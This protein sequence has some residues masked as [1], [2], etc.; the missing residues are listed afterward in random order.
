MKLPEA[1]MKIHIDADGKQYYI[2]SK[3]GTYTGVMFG[4]I[5]GKL[6]KTDKITV[7][8]NNYTM[9]TNIYW[10]LSDLVGKKDGSV[11]CFINYKSILREDLGKYPPVE[12]D[13]EFGRNDVYLN[14]V[15]S[16]Q[17]FDYVG[18]DKDKVTVAQVFEFDKNVVIANAALKNEELSKHKDI[19][20]GQSVTYKLEL[21]NTSEE[22]SMD[23][24]GAYD[25]LPQTYGRFEWSKDNVS[26]KAI[27]SLPEGNTTADVWRISDKNRAGEETGRY[28]IY[29]NDSETDETAAKIK[30]KPN[31]S[32]YIYVTLT[33]PLD[34]AVWSEYENDTFD[35]G[36]KLI[37]S[38]YVGDRQASVEHQIKASGEGMLQKGVYGVYRRNEG[39]SN[40]I[41]VVNSGDRN[42]YKNQA[43]DYDVVSYYVTIY[44]SGNARLYL[45]DI[46]DVLPK[47]FEYNAMFA[48]SDYGTG[49]DCYSGGD[50]YSSNFYKRANGKF[51]NYS[52]YLRTFPYA[53]GDKQDKNNLLA[54]VEDGDR[55]IQYM[56]AYIKE[57][58]I[59]TTNADG[60]VSQKLKFSVLQK[61]PDAT[62]SNTPDTYT[63]GN[64]KYDE[65]RG[66]CYLEKGQA[67]VFGYQ[68]KIL[69]ADQTDD[70]ANNRIAMQYYDYNDAGGFRLS[71]NVDVDA[72]YADYLDSVNDGSSYLTNDLEAS[73]GGF[74]GPYGG[75][76][77]TS[78][79]ALNRGRIIPG[80][81]KTLSAVM[82]DKGETKPV[83]N[84]ALIASSDIAVWTVT[85]TNDGTNS[86]DG[87]TISDEMQAPYYF[88]GDISYYLENGRKT[89]FS[90][91]YN[92]RN[93][94][95]SYNNNR[96]TWKDTNPDAL[97]MDVKF[98]DAAGNEIEKSIKELGK[99]NVWV[100]FKTGE[101]TAQNVYELTEHTVALGEECTFTSV[102]AGSHDTSWNVA[103]QEFTVL[104]DVNEKGNC[105]LDITVR[106]H[107]PSL[108]IPVSGKAVLTVRTKKPAS[109]LAY[110]SY[111]NTA[112]LAPDQY[113]E[114]DAVSKGAVIRDENDNPVSVESTS[115]L[116]LSGA[117]AT[118]SWKDITDN[119]DPTNTASSL[120]TSDNY[121][122]LKWDETKEPPYSDFTYSLNVQ[123]KCDNP[124]YKMV[125]I[126]N[127]PD[128]GDFAAYS[129]GTIARNS[130]FE[131]SLTGTDVF[132]VSDG[133]NM[134]Q[135]VDE[136]SE[137]GELVY[138]AEFS[139]GV[140]FT[141][142]DWSGKDTAQWMSF[143]EVNEKLA[144]GE[145]NMS[146]IRSYRIIVSGD[147]DH[148]ITMGGTLK[149]TANARISGENVKPNEIAW[150]N[151]GYKYYVSLGEN[152]NFALS[153]SSLNVGVKTATIPKLKKELRS[154]TGAYVSAERLQL[155]AE[156]I[157]YENKDEAQI[158]YKDD[159][160]LLK[161]LDEGGYKFTSI[162]LTPDQLFDSDGDG[163]VVSL[164]DCKIFKAV[165][166]D[167][168][169]YS[170]VESDEEDSTWRWIEDSKYTF[171]EINIPEEIV[172]ATMNSS[173]KNG[174]TITYK[175]TGSYT[176]FCINN[177]NDYAMTLRKTDLETRSALSGASFARYG[178]LTEVPANEADERMKQ[179]WSVNVDKYIE[180]SQMLNEVDEKHLALSAPN[181]ERL[182]AAK[183]KSFAEFMDVNGVLAKITDMNDAG[184][185]FCQ[186]YTFDNGDG[187]LNIYYF[188]DYNVT[189]EKGCISYIGISDDSLAFREIAAP[190][191]YRLSY[192]MIVANRTAGCGETQYI[193]IAD[194]RIT[195][196]PMTGGSGTLIVV[197]TGVF[198]M[199]SS[200]V[201]III[202]A[203]RRRKTFSTH[204]DINN[205]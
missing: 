104:F 160:D 63:T 93:T 20:R 69:R 117:Y 176:V 44:N 148:G 112:N 71:H 161:K 73:T 205:I 59:S 54:Y 95:S 185:D 189:D 52:K 149:V 172:F 175:P 164:T 47:G 56:Q 142:D 114:A 159:Q 190:Q 194:L 119:S 168:G 186:F 75:D 18:G 174:C 14:R 21:H 145:L 134:L 61:H 85:M 108:C 79:V 90:P 158:Q 78:D 60:E 197:C 48:V 64:I 40:D 4:D 109:L 12:G 133:E 58:T 154:P 165:K 106:D 28:Y 81:E 113:Y 162:K 184:N 32:L 177:Y 170:F 8:K 89:K 65:E 23:I 115:M 126:D 15:G 163:Q 181:A 17:L 136:P 57:E 143:D 33:F 171:V 39:T 196:L 10:Y 83:S 67:L 139:V 19:I 111:V 49:L 29:W 5:D 130:Q 118:I 124:L 36:N 22:Y 122:V 180:A 51:T 62:P 200:S 155:G 86:I 96:P 151:F 37:N 146:D 77:L 135:R 125:V 46:T 30:L 173:Q 147:A 99:E 131:V 24:T 43:L 27:S 11:S 100:K 116:T 88:T 182:K 193:D 87:Y 152:K 107:L 137:T 45:T 82:N 188:I 153:A 140:E 120:D 202:R 2:L 55:K 129:S 156:F 187:T 195:E 13:L 183:D 138:T 35:N 102:W 25:M 141:D 41:Q 204:A 128:K 192:S 6:L 31:E 178:V 38:F 74:D 191:S 101:Q 42:T 110:D 34:Q 98:V 26:M 144:S 127:L 7:K 76:W 3:A 157:V 132:T 150:N 66:L 123:N 92:P 169:V 97:M 1:G 166:D 203:V 94:D 80:I 9:D 167:D 198:L 179:L 91:T 70:L 68:A 103:K 84:G 50:Y 121:I 16:H 53:E 201:S 199:L 72:N 105:T